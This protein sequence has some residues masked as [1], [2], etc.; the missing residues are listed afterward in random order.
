MQQDVQRSSAPFLAPFLAQ[1]LAQLLAPCSARAPQQLPKVRVSFRQA[2]AQI[3]S[4]RLPAISMPNDRLL[5]SAQRAAR[6]YHQ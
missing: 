2:C 6:A 4:C 5:S 3:L 1:Q